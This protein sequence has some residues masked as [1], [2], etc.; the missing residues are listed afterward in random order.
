MPV[1]AIVM[2]SLANGNMRM[3]LIM[4]VELVLMQM[5][6]AMMYVL[7]LASSAMMMMVMMVMIVFMMFCALA[8]NCRVD[9][10]ELLC[11]APSPYEIC[12]VEHGERM[13]HVR[14]RWRRR[15]N[16]RLTAILVSELT[17]SRGGIFRDGKRHALALSMPDEAGPLRRFSLRARRHVPESQAVSDVILDSLEIR[18]DEVVA[19]VFVNEVHNHKEDSET[20]C[21]QDDCHHRHIE[22]DARLGPRLV[23]ISFQAHRRRTYRDAAGQPAPGG[24]DC[25]S[26]FPV[27]WTFLLCS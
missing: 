20:C 21:T 9:A 15:L 1:C 24:S 22:R 6:I 5:W 10:H 17:R 23:S 25:L 13:W 16:V 2:F 26:G 4:L 19:N 7:Q 14:C 12:C 18:Y 8:E 3:L 27:S 11:D